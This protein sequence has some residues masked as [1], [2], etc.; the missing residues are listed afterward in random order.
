MKTL[1]NPFYADLAR[2]RGKLGIAQDDTYESVEGLRG[3]DYTDFLYGDALANRI[4]GGALRAMCSMGAARNDRVIGGLGDD[5]IAGGS[6]A[7]VIDGQSGEDF[8]EYA[9]SAAGVTVDL[10]LAGGVQVSGGDASGD[11]LTSIEGLFGSS[12]NDKLS[13][14]ALANTL[15]GDG[16]ADVLVGRDGNDTL[17]GGDGADR[18]DGGVGQRYGQL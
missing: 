1:R 11:R 8:A 2:H 18:M 13:G 7:D 3:G 16:A 10:A 17:E 4:E 6:G 9:D 14:N 5:L 15:V 12:F